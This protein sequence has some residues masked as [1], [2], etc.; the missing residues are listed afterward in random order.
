MRWI[1]IIIH[2]NTE[3]LEEWNIYLNCSEMG[4]FAKFHL[5]PVLQSK[6]IFLQN[7]WLRNSTEN[8]YCTEYKSKHIYKDFLEQIVQ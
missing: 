3:L 5:R 6:T 4:K 7:D 8:I 2:R 1:S